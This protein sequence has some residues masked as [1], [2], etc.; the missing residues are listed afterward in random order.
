MSTKLRIIFN[1]FIFIFIFVF[2]IGLGF[3]VS[4]C[5]FIWAGYPIGGDA[6]QHL[7]R[8]RF[9][10]EFF[11]HYHW[12]NLWAGGIPRFI[13]YPAAPYLVLGAFRS[14][15]HFSPEFILTAVAVLAVGLSSAGVYLLTWEITK[16]RLVSLLAAILYLIVPSSWY[17]I[18][19]AVYARI[20]AMPLM[21]FSF[22]AFVRFWKSYQTGE[23]HKN[24]W[25][26]AAALLGLSFIFHF[27]V[28]TFTAGFIFLFGL[29]TTKSWK[30]FFLQILKLFS[31]SALLS[32][33]FW[34][35]AL[36]L[37]MPG[38]QTG[39]D[40]LATV[41]KQPT[42]PWKDLFFWRDLHYTTQFAPNFAFLPFFVLGGLALLLILALIFKRSILSRKTFQGRAIY[43]FLG[44]FLLA[45]LYA[46]F[47]IARFAYFYSNVLPPFWT[48]YYYP[49][50]LAPV[51]A[52]LFAN[53]FPRLFQLILFLPIIGGLF[54]WLNWQFPLP[55][56]ANL[57][58]KHFQQSQEAIFFDNVS[59]RFIPNQQQ[60][61]YRV[62]TGN[63]AMLAAWFNNNN[64][65]LPQTREYDY[66]SVLKPDWYF[67]L[68]QA[69]W[70][71][72]G[73]LPET[74]FLL[75]W[76]AVKQFI[77]GTEGDEN[78]IGGK[79]EDRP[80]DYLSLGEM[81]Y[82]GTSPLPKTLNYLGF[83]YNFASPIL[84]ATKTPAI[85]VVGSKEK[86]YKLIFKSLAYANLNSQ[87]AIPVWGG[88][89][90]DSL[91][92]Q[93]L[94]QFPV[95]FLYN[96]RFKNQAKTEKLLREY[97]ETGGRLIVEPNKEGETQNLD[98]FPVSQTDS[99][100]IS[101][102][103]DFTLTPEGK[104]QF[105]N[106]SVDNF[107]KPEYDGGPWGAFVGEQL[108][109][110]A[111]SLLLSADQPIL[112]EQELGEGKVIWSG[113]N[114][115]Y[116]IVSYQNAEESQLLGDLLGLP[117]QKQISLQ[118]IQEENLTFKTDD[119]EVNFINPQ[120]REI[121]ISSSS[122][123]GVLFKEFYFK[124]WKAIAIE[125]GKRKTLRIYPAGPEF[126]FIPFKDSSPSQIILEYH[127]SW[128]EKI[129]LFVSLISWLILFLYLLGGE[130]LR[131]I[132]LLKNRLKFQ[133]TKVS[134]WWDKEE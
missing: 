65:Y 23:F 70:N 48:V 47:P 44:L 26:L 61:N 67:Y 34:F 56:Q 59:K 7:F 50:F 122:L 96:Y 25:I 89:W 63:F 57:P 77:T 62:G 28:G 60:F 31:F 49:L 21:V 37:K 105:P 1:I 128:I 109:P 24:S 93:E 126:M 64:L 116:H 84:S 53:I 74:N 14:L 110:D 114:L 13:W 131:F 39:K 30:V 12:L 112:V 103:W 5:L 107:A 123:K 10:N 52:I 132:T 82:D 75:D 117:E 120:K 46:Q 92:S 68:V 99:I 127:S 17:L 66:L 111:Y 78:K 43:G 41:L 71:W 35:P 90:I 2:L 4:Y 58:Y 9:I 94:K 104:E 115:P 45:L 121:K 8:F 27:A 76:W 22:W 113:L 101:Q 51:L 73:N 134:Q 81:T 87:Q 86:A 133:K 108:K 102:D 100:N 95:I 83:E 55:E 80:N 97:V 16:N 29:F 118:N 38:F 129:G 32:A 19:A 42:L 124:N 11:P 119:Y 125:D 69:T 91:N 88:E 6:P 20:I 79:F 106:F 72:K 85:L 40:I 98:I 36:A 130:K 3:V 15:I 54:F 18:R 33:I